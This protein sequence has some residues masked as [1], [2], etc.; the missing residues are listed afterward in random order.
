MEVVDE[1]VQLS[2]AAKFQIRGMLLAKM[3][4]LQKELAEL[5]SQVRED[6]APGVSSG[7]SEMTF[8]AIERISGD[9]WASPIFP[10][11]VQSRT[12]LLGRPKSKGKSSKL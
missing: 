3:G 9:G 6:E 4:G 2:S 10:R 12:S 5:R 8:G 1:Q 11:A 7:T